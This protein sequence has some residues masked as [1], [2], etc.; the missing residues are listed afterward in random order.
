MLGVSAAEIEIRWGK[1]VEVSGVGLG[2]LEV[3]QRTNWS[4]SQ[5]QQLLSVHA[6]QG[7]LLTDLNM[8]AILGSYGVESNQVRFAPQF[9]F[10]PGVNYRAVFRPENIPGG[11][12]KPIS[13]TFQWPLTRT[14]AT[15]RVA[16]V[17]P[18]ADVLPENILKFYIQ[19]S[20]SMSGGRI[21]EHIHLRDASGKAVQ[22][23]F[24]EID[25]E[26]WN[27]DM[28]RLTLFLDPGRIKR[29]VRPLEEVGP[30]LE[31]G[32]SYTLTVT[33]DWR[34]A[35]G[36]PLTADFVK[37]FAV[38][39][40]DRESPD[41][42]K[43]KVE[44]PRSKK[45]IPV[46]VDF[47]EALDHAIAQRALRVIDPSGFAVAGAVELDPTD[48]QWSFTP[49]QPWKQGAYQI[50][51]PTIIEDLAGN[52]IGK[53]FDVDLMRGPQLMTNSM[54]KIPFTVR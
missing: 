41:P 40:A 26:L 7:N 2:A 32:K 48:H 39:A 51:V 17:Y 23:P 25:E 27:R 29:G 9:P 13:S 19:F 47:K 11:G 36:L 31:P 54:V 35:N 46:R 18:A 30:S 37:K 15:T 8:P 1:N 28:T 34:D 43:W 12:G 6:E 10:E 42:A 22:L 21:Y 49:D 5:W 16:A 24:L 45:T 4:R 33:R 50:L 44:A 52:N 53:P 14:Q 3:L 38:A 20:A